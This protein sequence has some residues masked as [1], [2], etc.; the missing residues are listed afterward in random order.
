MAL[1][2]EGSIEVS[3]KIAITVFHIGSKFF[4][5]NHPRLQQLI[6]WSDS[7]LTVEA[8]VECE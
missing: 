6:H 3:V 1:T 8:I 5:S 4:N 7:G 2:F